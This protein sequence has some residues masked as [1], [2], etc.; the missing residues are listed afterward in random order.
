MAPLSILRDPALQVLWS[1]YREA[2]LRAVSHEAKPLQ[3]APIRSPI[4]YEREGAG[5]GLRAGGQ[6]PEGGRGSRIES[7]FQVQP[8]TA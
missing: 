7:T 2:S 4:L 8:S 3:P 6:R 5:M 1:E